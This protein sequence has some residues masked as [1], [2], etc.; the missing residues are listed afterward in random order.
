[1]TG[2]I[3]T[4]HDSYIEHVVPTDS[5]DDGIA[6]Y[7]SYYFW[8]GA[9][10]DQGNLVYN[11]NIVELTHENAVLTSV[12]EDLD[13][14]LERYILQGDDI[15]NAAQNFAFDAQWRY[16][17]NSRLDVLTLTSGTRAEIRFSENEDN[18]ATIAEGTSGSLSGNIA[19]DLLVEDAL[20]VTISADGNEISTIVNDMPISSIVFTKESAGNFSYVRHWTDDQDENFRQTITAKTVETALDVDEVLINTEHSFENGEWFSSRQVKIT[21]IDDDN[22]GSADRFMQ[23]V[24]WG[25]RFTD[26]GVLVDYDGIAMSYD[27]AYFDFEVTSYEDEEVNWANNWV[28]A[29]NP[30]TVNSALTIYKTHQAYYYLD[31]IGRLSLKDNDEE[32]AALTMGSTTSFDL[33]NTMPDVTTSLENTDVFLDVN[34][35][36]ALEVVLGEYQVNLT[37]SGERTSLDDGKFDVAM[38]YKLPNETEQRSFVIHANTEEEGTLSANNSEDVLLVLRELPED[39]DSNVIGTIVVGA[40][41]VEAAQIQDR[42]NGL[43]MIVYADGTTDSL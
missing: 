15:S 16:R 10:D 22:D 14:L 31:G 21:P 20:S 8:Y 6:D 37:L 43:I 29:F 39:S 26:E 2:Y 18:L 4:T 40:A 12:S 28:L 32:Y 25:D 7:Y 36:L 38:S 3:Y 11:D 23:L 33:Y 30:M 42:G 19:S 34:A 27:N 13:D 5:D 41:A 35:A 9:M 24:L 1:M 17:G